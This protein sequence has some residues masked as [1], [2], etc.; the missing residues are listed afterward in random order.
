MF[1][2]E[3]LEVAIGIIFVFI[4]ASILCTTIREGL[5]AWLKTRAVYLEHGIREL[6][7]AKRSENKNGTTDSSKDTDLATAFYAHPLI[8]SLFSG[9]YKPK[10]STTWPLLLTRGVNLPSYIPSKNFALALMDIAAHGP[11]AETPGSDSSAPVISLETLRANVSK[12][13]NPAVQRV[14]LTAVD[15]AQGDITR[16]Q[17]NIEA[18]YDSTMDRVS[19]WYKRS[20]QGLIF[21]LGLA[22]AVGFNINTITVA[23]YLYRNGAARAAIVARAGAASSD[24]TYLNNSYAQVKEDL[25]AMNLPIGWAGGWGR[26]SRET[27]AHGITSSRRFSVGS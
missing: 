18:W 26:Q 7:H 14:L 1:G 13:Q 20:T 27:Q 4:L 16:V 2:S 24:Q 5:E 19:G 15:S 11:E 23:D 25:E 8:F 10:S 3:I 21:A 6:L 9:E 22:V 12:L 17:A